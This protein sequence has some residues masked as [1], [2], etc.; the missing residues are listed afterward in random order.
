M[1]RLLLSAAFFASI[2]ASSHAVLIDF[3]D[4]SLSEGSTLGS[5]Y[6]GKGVTF[7]AGDLTGDSTWFF[8]STTYGYGTW[9]TNSGLTATESDTLT[10]AYGTP[11]SRFLVHSATDWVDEDGDPI[12][13]ASF[14]TLANSISVDFTGDATAFSG[15][16]LYKGTTYV[17]KALV[18]SGA[19]STVK[20]AS[21][22]GASFDHAYI[23]PGSYD[24]WV[25][26]SSITF[27]P[28]P[29]PETLGLFALSGVALLRRRKSK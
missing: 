26:V 29:E 11:A 5:Q 14:A 27:N 7:A 3:N 16:A 19:A 21:F 25:G 13:K 12:I 15:I 9:A 8:P 6:S 20:T 22:S 10:N 17:G 4:G 28:V 24:D 23:I 18:G 1:R 2:V